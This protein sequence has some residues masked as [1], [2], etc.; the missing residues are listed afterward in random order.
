MMYRVQ[1]RLY[2]LREVHKIIQGTSSFLNWWWIV[3][4]VSRYI[5]SVVHS[6]S[7]KKNFFYHDQELL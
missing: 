3:S 4:L 5:E 1:G 7:D 6:N 2:L